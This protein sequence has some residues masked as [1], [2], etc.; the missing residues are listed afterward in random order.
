MDSNRIKS[1]RLH[2]PGI[3]F[4]ILVGKVSLGDKDLPP[5]QRFLSF[6]TEILASPTLRRLPR[7]ICVKASRRLAAAWYLPPQAPVAILFSISLQDILPFT[8]FS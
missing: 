1:L 5:V 6:S 2:E 3:P 7:C 8:H 4:F